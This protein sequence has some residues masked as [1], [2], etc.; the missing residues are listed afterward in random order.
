MSEATKAITEASGTCY[1]RLDKDTGPD[2]PVDEPFILGRP[3]MLR[4]G[5]DVALI[6]TGGILSEVIKAADELERVG[7][8]ASVCAVHT[9]RPFEPNRI[10]D[11]ARMHRGLVTVEEHTIHGGLGGLVLETLADAGIC[12]EKFLRIG[13]DGCFSSV[14]GSQ[15]YLRA[16]YGMDAASIVRRTRKL[17]SS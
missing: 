16:A 17:L 6:V 1:L 12:H 3:R 4:S 9:L 7:I 15:S 13:L 10:I 14:V 11:A 8:G 5:C 2:G